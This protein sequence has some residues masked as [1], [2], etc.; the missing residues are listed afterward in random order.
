MAVVFLTLNFS[1]E[2][3]SSE[4]FVIFHQFQTLGSV[5]FALLG[6]VPVVNKYV[7]VCGIRECV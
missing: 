5:L 6:R 7:C 3:H 2:S 4:I 1:M